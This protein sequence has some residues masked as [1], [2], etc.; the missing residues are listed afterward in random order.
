MSPARAECDFFGIVLDNFRLLRSGSHH[1]VSPNNFTWDHLMKIKWLVTN[2]TAVESPERAEH[3]ILGV[4]VARRA[5]GQ[6]RSYLGSG[7]HF[8]IWERNLE[9]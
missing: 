4:I 8:V 2:V 9:I 6:F 7:N 3:A 1:F 5:F